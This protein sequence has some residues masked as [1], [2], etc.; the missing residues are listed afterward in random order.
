MF[1]NMWLPNTCLLSMFNKKNYDRRSFIFFFPFLLE[2][3]LSLSLSL[4][5]F[6]LIL[7]RNQAFSSLFIL[8][9]VVF[10]Q[11][12]LGL[13]RDKIK[14]AIKVRIFHSFSFFCVFLH[15]FLSLFLFN[16]VFLIIL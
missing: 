12:F 3:C 16:F 4:S 10:L 7:T 1:K 5:L 14:H 9:Y 15:H 8:R 13:L 11:F 2:N 6:S